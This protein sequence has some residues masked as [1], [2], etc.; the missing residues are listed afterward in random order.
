MTRRRFMPAGQTWLDFVRPGPHSQE[1]QCIQ[2]GGWQSLATW[3]HSSS[4]CSACRNEDQR[5]L[6][7]TDPH[8][9]YV[10]R[11]R[12]TLRRQAATTAWRARQLA[13]LHPGAG[14]PCA[15]P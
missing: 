6:Y 2:C 12:S 9:R 4:R 3:P 7:R 10:R 8:E 15:A 5:A 13:R 11:D 14:G 1:R